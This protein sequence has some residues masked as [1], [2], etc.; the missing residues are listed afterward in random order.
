MPASKYTDEAKYLL[1]MDA[2]DKRAYEAAA[3]TDRL[4]LADWINMQLRK[5][6]RRRVRNAIS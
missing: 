3:K 5:E 1:R 6:L 4:T 2:E